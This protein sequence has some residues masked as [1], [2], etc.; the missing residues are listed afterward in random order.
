MKK[1]FVTGFA[2]TLILSSCNKDEK[3]QTASLEQQKLDYQVRQIE[4]EKQKLAIEKE[5]INEYP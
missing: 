4:L 3:L 5:K 2:A 1:L